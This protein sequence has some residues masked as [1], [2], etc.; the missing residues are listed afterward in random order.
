M[1]I[2]ISPLVAI[3]FVLLVVNRWFLAELM[4]YF[5][6][7]L[8]MFC[9]LSNMVTYEFLSSLFFVDKIR[10]ILSSLAF[11]IG[12]F[13]LSARYNRVKF[14]KKFSFL[15]IFLSFGIVLIL[16]YSFYSLSLLY[17]YIFFEV[18]LIPIFL[19]V[20]GWG[21]QPE[22]VQAGVYMLF[23]TL[24]GSLP[25]LLMILLVYESGFLIENR[26]G[27]CWKGGIRRVVSFLFLFAFLVKL[28]MFCVHLWLPKA[29]VEA[30]VAGSIILAALL[31][32]LGGYGIWRVLRWIKF[33]VV[34]MISIFIIIGLLGGVIVSFVCFIQVDIKALVAYSSVVHIGILLSGIRTIMLIGFDG[35]LIIMV[36]HGLVSSGLFFLV[37]CV[38]DRSGRRRLLLNKGIMVLF[39]RFTAI[40]FL[41]RIFNI[42]APPSLN[43][44]REI[45]LTT[46][47][48]AWRWKRALYLIMMNFMGIVF[49]FYLYA[50]SQQGKSLD[51]LI[52]SSL[53]FIREY[54]V[55]I[56]HVIFLLGL[57]FIFWLFYLN[58]LKKFKIVIFEM[59]FGFR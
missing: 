42:R 49:T 50:Q 18:V 43:L 21:Y 58:S 15:F 8:L 34:D 57:R 10:F 24:F 20:M 46:R 41:L 23:Y 47:I 29:H 59:P 52:R 11:L 51:S 2:L 36:G 14:S 16:L 39:P 9:C 45:L 44:L 3:R 53:I 32:K 27:L 12:G 56:G 5:F 40:W 19:I 6:S 1:I 33:I 38:Y 48:L 13:M 37:G 30:P 31:L 35:A 22:R 7:F 4:I 54:V 25:L 55:G 17:F 26:E 28:P